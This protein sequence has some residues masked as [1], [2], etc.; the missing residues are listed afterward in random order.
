M[1]AKLAWLITDDRTPNKS[2]TQKVLGDYG[3]TIANVMNKINE[4]SDKS[5]QP[6]QI[7]M[8]LKPHQLAMINGAHN[9][10]KVVSATFCFSEFM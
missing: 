6:T 2:A 1:L 8:L 9:L 4:N 7:K 5:A 3:I 10:V